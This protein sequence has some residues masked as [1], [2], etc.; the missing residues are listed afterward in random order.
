MCWISIQMSGRFRLTHTGFA[1]FLQLVSSSSIVRLVHDYGNAIRCPNC[2]PIHP[3]APSPGEVLIEEGLLGILTAG[4]PTFD[5]AFCVE[6]NRTRLE[7]W[8]PAAA[9]A[10]LVFLK[11]RQRETAKMSQLNRKSCKPG[12][13]LMI[14]CN[15][16]L[17]HHWLTQML[18][19][20]RGMC[21]HSC[22]LF[23]LLWHFRRKS[24][25]F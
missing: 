9:A 16:L 22:L 18:N 1:S 2:V 14:T 25:R 8:G 3:A 11:G 24:P 19:I 5:P 20:F 10:R 13:R 23:S 17:C 7:T 15:R 12:Q 4:D 21:V 6:C